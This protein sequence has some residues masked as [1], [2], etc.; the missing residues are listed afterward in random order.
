GD[1]SPTRRK[2][3][4]KPRCEQCDRVLPPGSEICPACLQRGKI[5]MR[6]LGYVR[7]YA[8]LAIL[9]FATTLVVTAIGLTPPMLMRAL[10]DDTSVLHS[11]CVDGLQNILVNTMTL[12]GIGVT[13]FLMNWQLALIVLIPT[14]V[15]VFGSKWFSRRVRVVYRRYYREWAAISG[16]LASTF[17]G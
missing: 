1:G 13:L 2:R 10:T 4:A 15:L 5:V 11:F 9:S 17:S 7:P 16:I 8:G 6:M 3:T 14:P 12:V